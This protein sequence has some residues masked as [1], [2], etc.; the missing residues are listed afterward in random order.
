LLTWSAETNGPF[1]KLTVIGNPTL[2]SV[3]ELSGS[4]K[5]RLGCYVLIDAMPDGGL[6]EVQAALYDFWSH[7]SSLRAQAPQLETRQR[8]DVGFNGY[9]EQQPLLLPEE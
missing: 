6:E 2:S 5:Q 1:V 3:D 7:Y 4:L 9:R 8:L